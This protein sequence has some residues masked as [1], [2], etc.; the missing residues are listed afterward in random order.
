MELKIKS[1][2][3]SNKTSNNHKNVN[4]LTSESWKHVHVVCT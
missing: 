2:I 1:S 3:S 4:H